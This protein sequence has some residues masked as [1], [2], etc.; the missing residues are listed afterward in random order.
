MREWSKNNAEKK[1][2]STLNWRTNNK[3]KMKNSLNDYYQS[4]KTEITLMNKAWADKNPDKV[5]KAK[6][7]WASRNIESL[8]VKSR[9]W[10]KKNP[11]KAKILVQN[12]RARRL[13]SGTRLSYGITRKVLNEQGHKCPGCLTCLD[14][15][16]FHIDHFTPLVLGG[17]HDDNNIQILCASCNLKK[18]KK[19]PMRWLNEI[20]ET[21]DFI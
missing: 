9:E 12:R 10:S 15:T 18:S 8:R 3:E 6:S 5:K 19:H 20:L 1:R 7:E 14:S 2:A 4:H 13:A 17:L 11:D 16:P 21:T